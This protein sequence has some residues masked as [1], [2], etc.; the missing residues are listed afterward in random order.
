MIDFGL[1]VETTEWQLKKV[2]STRFMPPEAFIRGSIRQTNTTDRTSLAYAW[3][4]WGFAMVI[5]DTISFPLGSTLISE[6]MLSLFVFDGGSSSVVD[7]QHVTHFDPD[8]FTT[9]MKKNIGRLQSYIS[10][11]KETPETAEKSLEIHKVLNLMRECNK[12]DFLASLNALMNLN[13]MYRS[14]SE[15]LLWTAKHTKDEE[16]Q[17]EC[18]TYSNPARPNPYEGILGEMKKATSAIVVPPNIQQ[19]KTRKKVKHMKYTD[20]DSLHAP[21]LPRQTTTKRSKGR[22]RACF[23]CFQSSED[24]DKN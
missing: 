5:L 17:R 18:Y 9:W 12:P 23:K 20:I 7:T 6:P 11:L 13:V 21:L 22:F 14:I 3:D 15:Y 10:S 19:S 16:L 2:G 24:D 8:A 4:H 1:S